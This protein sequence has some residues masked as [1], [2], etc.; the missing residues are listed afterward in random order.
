M[1][2]K[3]H[4]GIALVDWETGDPEGDRKHLFEAYTD[5][6]NELRSIDHEVVRQSFLKWDVR[7][8]SS[9]DGFPRIIIKRPTE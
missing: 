2:H 9:I 6:L 8:D 4:N 1:A 3:V 7:T 5:F